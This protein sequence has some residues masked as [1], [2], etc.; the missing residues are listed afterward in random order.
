MKTNYQAL[1]DIQTHYDENR[2]D[3]Q[4]GLLRDEEVEFIS[5][6]LSLE[7]KDLIQLQDARDFTVMYLHQLAEEKH[8]NQEVNDAMFILDM[9]S[10][11]VCVIDKYKIK[12]G[13]KI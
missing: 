4:W 10:A 9:M 13:G 12:L 3:I 8:K 1:I 5:K 2:G 11:I 7:E 6:E